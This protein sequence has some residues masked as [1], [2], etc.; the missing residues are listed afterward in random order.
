M[1]RYS[2]LSHRAQLCLDYLQLRLQLLHEL[3]IFLPLVESN[4]CT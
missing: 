3:R 1:A 2:A 4:P